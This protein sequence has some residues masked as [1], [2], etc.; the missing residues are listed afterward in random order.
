MEITA[1]IHTFQDVLSLVGIEVDDSYDR[2]RLK[3]G[4]LGFDSVDEKFR[5]TGDQLIV[6][7]DGEEHTVLTVTE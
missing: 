4:G 5:V 3:I 2:R 1:G 7:L 6:T